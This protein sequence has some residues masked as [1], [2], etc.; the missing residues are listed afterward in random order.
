MKPRDLTSLQD[1]AAQIHIILAYIERHSHET[2]ENDALCQD[3]VI[4][5][6]EIIGE[7]TTRLS[8]EFRQQH[9][10]V[11]WRMIDP[12]ASRRPC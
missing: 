9:P 4:R 5:R 8:E 7:A 2:F 6:L 11:N 3:A 10:E 1:I 12:I